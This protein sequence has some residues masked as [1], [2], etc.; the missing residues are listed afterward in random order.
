MLIFAGNLAGAAEA[1]EG[2]KTCARAKILFSYEVLTPYATCNLAD[3]WLFLEK[4]KIDPEHYEVHE[5]DTQPDSQLN[6]L[7]GSYRRH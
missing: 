7:P 5:I 3:A 6:G 1:K 2:T 4:L